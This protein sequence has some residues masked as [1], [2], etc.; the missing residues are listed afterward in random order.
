MLPEVDRKVQ[1]WRYWSV[2]SFDEKEDQGIDRKLYNNAQ[3]RYDALQQL[4]TFFEEASIEKTES[5]QDEKLNLEEV[6]TSVSPENENTLLTI[7]DK[8][9]Y[10]LN[11]LLYWNYY[12]LNKK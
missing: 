4:L 9:R 8:I 7:K 12:L 5:D 11:R 3:L 2:T 10:A 1:V 6:E